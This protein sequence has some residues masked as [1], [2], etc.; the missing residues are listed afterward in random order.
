[1][2]SSVM[3]R[4]A[5]LLRPRRSI[6]SLRLSTGGP[7]TA[8]TKLGRRL[9]STTAAT[10]KQAAEA[11]KQTTSKAASAVKETTA[12]ATSTASEYTARASQG[13]SR[14]TSAAGP[15]ISGAA[16]GV[17]KALG[18]VGG[19]TGRLIA[20]VEGA[21]DLWVECVLNQ[22]F[23]PSGANFSGVC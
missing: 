21:F 22:G 16:Q 17:S 3:A 14:V 2:S 4:P 13:L 23:A 8:A 7:R 1:M 6:V 18:R 15:A 12:K 11:A 20:F 19:R 5:L 9:E 10:T